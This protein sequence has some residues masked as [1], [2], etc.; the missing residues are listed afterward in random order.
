M[1]QDYEGRIDLIGVAGS[2]GSVEAMQGFVD[3]TGVDGFP[4]IADTS[5]DVWS[6]YEIRTQP[7]FVF[8]D[9]DGSFEVASGMGDIRDRID[10]LLAT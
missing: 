7:R 10:A 6:F 3:S 1:Q 2:S 8:I 5:N 9:D 4:H